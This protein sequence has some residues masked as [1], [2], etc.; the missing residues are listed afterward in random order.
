ML[1]RRHCCLSSGCLPAFAHLVPHHLAQT[2]NDREPNQGGYKEHDDNPN[3]SG[4]YRLRFHD[5]LL[6]L[7]NPIFWTLDKMI[8]L[9][10]AEENTL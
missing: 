1:L 2:S 7:I 3:Q 4:N 5:N 6:S 10:S 8:H 9:L